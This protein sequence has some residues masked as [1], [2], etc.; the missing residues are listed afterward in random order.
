MK[1]QNKKHQNAKSIGEK[2]KTKG[3]CVLCFIFFMWFATF[4]ILICEPQSIWL[5]VLS[6]LYKLETA[7][8]RFHKQIKKKIVKSR[9]GSVSWKLR[10]WNIYQTAFF[11][12]SL[13]NSCILGI[14]YDKTKRI[15]QITILSIFTHFTQCGQR[16]YFFTMLKVNILRTWW[17]AKPSLKIGSVNKAFL[18]WYWLRPKKYFFRNFSR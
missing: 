8:K 4:Q 12:G 17:K 18:F 2:L 10:S 5:L 16:L 11:L 7:L 3:V 6:W 15:N 13:L 1:K 14:Q 9:F